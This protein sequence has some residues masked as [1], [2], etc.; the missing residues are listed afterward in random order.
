MS[1]INPINNHVGIV[2][3]YFICVKFLGINTGIHYVLLLAYS[4]KAG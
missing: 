4:P 2:Q 1:V 3:Y